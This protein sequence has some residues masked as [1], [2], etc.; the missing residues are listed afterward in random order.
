MLAP[1]LGFLWSFSRVFIKAPCGRQRY[2]VLGALN[3]I[4]LYFARE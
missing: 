4:T 3:A 2:N 1:F